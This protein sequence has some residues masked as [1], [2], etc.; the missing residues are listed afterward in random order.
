ML[1]LLVV[2]AVIAIAAVAL[3]AVRGAGGRRLVGRREHVPA[4]R[5]SA[6]A[7][8]RQRARR[9]AR[10][11]TADERVL[12]AEGE[13]IQEQ[14]E[15]RLSA[16]GIA[17][18]RLSGPNPPTVAERLAPQAL[19][20]Q[21]QARRSAPGIRARGAGLPQGAYAD[22]DLLVASDPVLPGEPGYADDGSLGARRRRIASRRLP[23]D[24]RD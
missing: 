2:I 23:P 8:R 22:P 5:G 16:Q 21:A 17:A 6:G 7:G 12:F 19:A 18:H 4:R 1:V 15:A 3:L 13:E 24:L 11:R 10:H 20:N 9:V 14:V